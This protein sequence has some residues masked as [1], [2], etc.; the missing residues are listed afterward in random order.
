MF[1]GTEVEGFAPPPKIIIIII[2]ILNVKFRHR[3]DG[4]S[5]RA[6]KVKIR[7][8]VIGCY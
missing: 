2:I 5:L 4:Y 3:I 7:M 6:V 1:R 8:Y